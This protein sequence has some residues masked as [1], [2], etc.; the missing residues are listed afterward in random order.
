MAS[1][2]GTVI[3]IIISAL[4]GSQADTLEMIPQLTAITL[5]PVDLRT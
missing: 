4:V 5:N 2:R 1:T 3:V